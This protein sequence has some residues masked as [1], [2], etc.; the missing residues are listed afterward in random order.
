L[1]HDD[2]CKAVGSVQSLE[3]R[4]LSADEAKELMA[5]NLPF[6]MIPRYQ[7]FDLRLTGLE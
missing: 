6:A 7:L 1:S 3:G 2:V 4:N 5:Q